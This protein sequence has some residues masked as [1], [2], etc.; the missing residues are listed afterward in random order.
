MTPRERVLRA[1]R[2]EVPDR[3]PKE[4]GFTPAAYDRFVKET[5]H[6]DPAEYFGMETR[7][8]GFVRH[9]NYRTLHPI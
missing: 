3:V 4:M 5:G 1:I 2:R 9:A 7:Y 8:V 6:T